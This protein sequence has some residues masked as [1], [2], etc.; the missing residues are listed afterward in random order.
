MPNRLLRSAARLSLV[1]VSV[2]LASPAAAYWEYGHQTVAKIAYASVRPATRA[3]LNALL[4]HGDLLGTPECAVSDMAS[5]STWADCIKPLKDANGKSRFGYA[6][7]WH[8]QDVDVCKPF[9]LVT[10]CKDGNCVSAQI[11]R[12]QARLADRH[13]PLTDRVQALAFLTH[14]VG[15]LSQPLHAGEH[16]DQGGNKIK[17]SFGLIAGRTNLHSI[18]DGYLAERAISTPPGGERGLLRSTP[19]AERRAI[20]A[21]DVTDWSRDSW[22]VSRD[23]AYGSLVGDPCDG[24]NKPRAVMDEAMVERLIPAAR[25]QV[26]KG[27]LRLA[28]LLD[29]ALGSRS[30]R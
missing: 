25:A 13:L 24:T 27:G 18:W 7:S 14:F 4:R 29:A 26:V 28:K 8:F 9:D 30:G 23:V 19:R 3:R 16:D 2:G 20:V 21:G 11:V 12:Q 5:A 6:Y 1:A 15:D 17:A 22:Q 10:P